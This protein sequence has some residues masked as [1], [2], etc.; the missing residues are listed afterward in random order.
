MKRQRSAVA[1]LS[2]LDRYLLL[3]ALDKRISVLQ[4]KARE[5]AKNGQPP[6]PD[7]DRLTENFTALKE[8]LADDQAVHAINVTV[9]GTELAAKVAQRLSSDF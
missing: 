2:G 3:D 7:L 8:R 5:R 1:A 6:R 4:I 9:L